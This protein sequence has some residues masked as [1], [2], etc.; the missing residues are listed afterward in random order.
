MTEECTH[1]R[2]TKECPICQKIMWYPIHIGSVD[3]QA[4]IDGLMVGKGFLSRDEAILHHSKNP[5]YLGVVSSR[6]F[7]P[8]IPTEK[9]PA[10]FICV[11][12]QGS[13]LY[14]G[15]DEQACQQIAEATGNDYA[16]LYL[17]K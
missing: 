15:I 2:L 5:T 7:E 6:L 13:V 3:G 1:H 11:N 9:R 17:K 8:L 12:P 14:L 4:R 10:A 16:G